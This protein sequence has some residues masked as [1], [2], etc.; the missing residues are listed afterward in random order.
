MHACTPHTQVPATM[1]LASETVWIEGGTY[2]MGHEGTADASPPLEQTVNGFWMQK[3][4][5]TNVQFEQFCE[6]TGYVTQ[7]EKTG[8]SYVYVMDAK[9]DPS[10]IPGAPWWKFTEGADWRH[11]QGKNSNISDKSFNPVTHVSQADACAYCEWLHMRLPT[12][13]EW[14]WAA[15]TDGDHPQKNVWQGP[16]PNRNDN[17]DGF[18]RTAPVGSFKPGK[19]GLFDISGNVWEWC[20]DKY[21]A[22]WYATGSQIA[23]KERVKGPT[24]SYDPAQPYNTSF[25]IRG[26]SFLC[27]E[28]YCT[29]YLPYTRMRADSTQTFEHIGFRC[30]RGGRGH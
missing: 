30:V 28:N 26:G 12:E 5:V 13:A 10:S 16:F 17:S 18:L 6:T 20:A 21:N 29:G 7:A 23:A 9:P 19:N 24:K 27:S 4:E 3:Y 11:P 14:E 22:G 2:P 15:L 8:G 1:E 25:V